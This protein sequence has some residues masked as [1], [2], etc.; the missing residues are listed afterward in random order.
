MPKPTLF[1]MTTLTTS[2]LCS[3]A[4][5][6]SSFKPVDIGTK[7]SPRGYWEFLPTAYASNPNKT[8]PLVIFFH[9]LG[10]GGNGKNDLSKVT[11]NGP[12]KILSKPSHPIYATIDQAQAIVLSPQTT[13]RT[14]WKQTHI[15]PFLDWAKTHYRIDPDRIYFT[16]LSAGSSGMADFINTDPKPGDIAAAL[17]VAV[18]GKVKENSPLAGKLPFWALTAKGDGS[19]EP[20]SSVNRLAGAWSGSPPTNVMK[21]YPGSKDT[22]TATF[23]PAKGWVW[24]TGT[25]AIP[26]STKLA[27]TLYPGD[28]HNSWDRTY[29]DPA[30]WQWLFAQ[31]K[32]SS[33]PVNPDMGT[34]EMDMATAPADMGDS[35]DMTP[36]GPDM[37]TVASD[38]ASAPD[39]SSG[40][41]GGSQAKDMAPAASQDLG[42]TV[43]TDMA[44]TQADMGP[45][46]KG[47]QPGGDTDDEGCATAG[48]SSTP[49]GPA[50][51]ILLLGLLGMGRR[52][53]RLSLRATR[54]ARHRAT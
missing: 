40:D 44:S 35:A 26:P 22:Q 51:P 36:Y 14:W 3:A 16:G 1:L 32:R 54:M 4:W 43:N 12:P 38:M 10:E 9:G 11:N 50:L 2:L 27:L 8:F 45:L 13:T 47:D 33:Q 20:V 28:A 53:H 42:S 31:T 5:A 7:G 39:A 29:D 25:A 15:R 30:V 34:V 18:R 23:D 49:S 48:K 21:T 24:S 37:S 19:S 52:R 41:Q 46:P 17:V 6:Q